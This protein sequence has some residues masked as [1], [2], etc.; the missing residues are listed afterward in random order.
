MKRRWRKR[1]KALLPSWGRCDRGDA[2]AGRVARRRFDSRKRRSR[3]HSNSS[4]PRS[5][6]CL[7]E[8]S[9][10]TSERDAFHQLLH[11]GG[12]FARPR[13]RAEKSTTCRRPHLHSALAGR[14]DDLRPPNHAE[15]TVGRHDLAKWRRLPACPTFKNTI[16]HGRL[17]VLRLFAYPD[18]DSFDGICPVCDVGNDCAQRLGN[19]TLAI[20]IC[21]VNPFDSVDQELH[22]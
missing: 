9:K 19:R 18:M 15:G 13:G 16:A 21:D 7:S 22:I 20:E 11:T 4:I 1:R 14:T 10:C 3:C 2:S 8:R 5:V 17:A 6:W 12:H